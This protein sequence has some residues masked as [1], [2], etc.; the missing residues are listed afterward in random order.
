MK[1]T[2]TRHSSPVTANGFTLV[3]LAIVL[4]IVGLLIGM[5]ATLIGPLTKRAKYNETK[6]TVKEVFETINGFAISNKRMPAFLTDLSVKATDSYG[7][8]LFYYAAGGITASN[9]CTT[10]GTYLTV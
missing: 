7:S 1:K 6:N 3:E 10:Q 9:P 2:V 5:G 8:N 4:V